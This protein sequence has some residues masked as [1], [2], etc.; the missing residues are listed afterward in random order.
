MREKRK[1]MKKYQANRKLKFVYYEK[2]AELISL[3]FFFFFC[4]INYGD[5]FQLFQNRKKKKK[6][7]LL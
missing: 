5:P 7:F 2:E 1:K 6:N 3:Y 4:C